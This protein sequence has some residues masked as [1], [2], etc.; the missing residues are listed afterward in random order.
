MPLQFILGKAGSGKT[1]YLYEEAIN[2]SIKE[3]GNWVLVIV[4]EQFT[5]QAQ[6]E[7]IGLHPSHGMMNIDVL[8]FKRLAYRVF[9]ELNVRL[10][11]VLDDMGKSMVLRRVMGPCKKS[12]GLYGGHLG[13]PGFINQMKSQL[14][15]LYQYGIGPDDL[16]ALEEETDHELLRQKLSDLE[17]VYRKFQD[18]IRDHYITAEEILDILCRELPGSEMIRRSVIFLDGYTGFTPVQYRLIRLFLTCAKD[19]VCAVTVDPK[20]GP[21]RESGIQNLFYMSK[22]T[23]CRLNQMAGEEKISRKTDVVLDPEPACRFKDSPSLDFLEQNLYRYSSKCWRGQP[24]EVEIFCGK[25]PAEEMDFVLKTME[26]MVRH[27]GYRYRDMAIVTGDLASY[28]RLAA[29]K[30]EQAGIPFFMDQKKSVLDNPM[31][32][33]IRA[34]VEAVRDFSY[35]NV[36]RYLKTGL[37]YDRKTAGLTEGGNSQAATFYGR[38]EAQ[39][40]TSRLENYVRALGLNG[41]KRWDETWEGIF[42]G[43]ENMN[44]EELNQFRL[45][46]LEPLRPLREAMKA[47]E[48]TIASMTEALKIWI[49]HME[50]KEKLEEYQEYF[51]DRGRF[52]DQNLSR[53]YGQVYDLVMELME[54]LTGLLGDEK[55]DQR[56][57]GQILDAGFEEIQ[58][59]TIPATIDQ[60][61]VGDITRSR[62]DGVKALFFVGVNDQIVPQRKNGGSLLSDRDREFFRAHS[63][64]LAPTVREESCMQKFYLYLILSKPSRRLCLTYGAAAADGKSMR[65]SSLIGEVRKLFPELKVFTDGKKEQPIYT[66]RDG[67]DGLI[68]GL[69]R[70]RES[71][72]KGQNCEQEAGFLELCRFFLSREDQREEF[73]RL[74]RGAFY[75]YQEKGIGKA[76]A[77][78]LYGPVLQGSVT[79]M[80]QYA[81][82]AYAHFLRYGLELLERREYR[83]EAVDVGNLFH[84]SIDLCFKR[85]QEEEK[86]WRTLSDEDRNRLAK[87]CVQQVVNQYGNTIL[88]SSARYSY[89]A[90]RVEQMTERTIWALGEQVKRG[91]FTP[92]GFEVVFSASDNLQAMRIGLGEGQ[93]LRLK[94]RIDRMDLCR[95]QEKLY[96]KI[97]DYKSGSTHFDLSALYYGLQ[98]QLVVYMD[99]AVEL[100]ERK[101]PE[102]QVIPAGIFYYNIQD[103]LVE[104]D[105]PMTDEEIQQEILKQLRMNGLVN[106]NLEVIRHLD[107]EIETQSD[108]IPVALKAGIIQENRSSVTD[109]KGFQYLKAYVI[110]RLRKAGQEILEGNTDLSP[111]KDMGRTSCD[112]CPYHAVCGF[113]TKTAGY[114]YRRLKALK[115]QEIWEDIR[116]EAESEEE[117]AEKPEKREGQYG[118]NMD[119]GPAGG[120]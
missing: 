76:A 67:K 18:Y 99:A 88:M 106:R 11:A 100:L 8:S 52:G 17:V 48:V 25:N 1:R 95:D 26:E 86:D 33:L 89:M 47:S 79:R 24:G 68:R 110:R 87:E 118:S 98:L 36:F 78:A 105:G 44:L 111:C 82:C 90:R 109:T 77:K 49:Q 45:W 3:P 29:R 41:W 96:V 114:G 35:E 74:V 23:V 62:L 116:K 93:E 60:V 31:V 5:M 32:E 14:S 12:L 117:Q 15:E 46:V 66:L 30:M 107:R 4:P 120:H 61:T 10:P 58:V 101:N 113:D 84:Q 64:E 80:E 57:Y 2:R 51:S 103:P 53:E 37:V 71:R 21:Y 56:T 102:S 83:L 70:Y 75:S 104:K 13:Q 16:K 97:I 22:H 119:Q 92:A 63:M 42:A 72:E 94:G 115:P 43:E 38:Q 69:G 65:P 85:V 91:D 39:I 27:Q 28:G 112:Y 6:R 55:V 108:V 20:A 59:G 81:S 73:I 54:R 9:D 7:I 40:W 50:L 34:A 19:V